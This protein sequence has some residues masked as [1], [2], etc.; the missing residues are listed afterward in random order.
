MNNFRLEID[1]DDYNTLEDLYVFRDRVN[2]LSFGFCVPRGEGSLLHALELKIRELQN[3]K[4]KELKLEVGKFYRNS[5][6]DVFMILHIQLEKEFPVLAVL[7][8]EKEH[9]QCSTFLLNGQACIEPCNKDLVEEV[10]D[11]T[12]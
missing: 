6:N 9:F 3:P 10:E 8:N 2:Q 7:V 5:D 11:P 4:P 12:L 1:L